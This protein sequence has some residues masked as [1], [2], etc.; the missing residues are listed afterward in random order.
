MTKE[1]AEGK[2][3]ISIPYTKHPDVNKKKSSMVT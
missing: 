1:G 3:R 2:E